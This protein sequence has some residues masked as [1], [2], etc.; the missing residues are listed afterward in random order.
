MKRKFSTK[1]YSRPAWDAAL[2]VICLSTVGVTVRVDASDSGTN[3]SARQLIEE[4]I[5]MGVPLYNGGQPEACAAVYRTALRSLELFVDGSVDKQLIQRALRA[6]AGQ[7]VEESA[8][9]LRYALDEVYARMGRQG[10]AS[11]DVFALDFSAGNGSAWYVVN[12]N[13]MGGVSQGGWMASDDEVGVFAG[14]LSL[15]NNGGFSSVRTR[16][17]S[18]ALAGQDG[19]EMRVRGDGRRYAMLAGIDNAQGSWQYAF[20]APE[21]WETVR[22]PFGQMALSIRGWR[23]NTYPPIDG[24]RVET[25]GFIISDKDERPFRMEIDWMRGYRQ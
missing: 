19:I 8:W 15:R 16:V 23:P 7:S 4:S 14:R 5:R 17:P 9:T 20:T 6:A 2:L 12:D 25:L 3:D 11:M 21:E 1:R 18:A 24:R 22:V 10:G 13:V